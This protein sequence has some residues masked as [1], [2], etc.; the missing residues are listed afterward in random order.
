MD[1]EL[2][3]SR[4]TLELLLS[5][6]LTIDDPSL[7]QAAEPAREPLATVPPR[8]SIRAEVSSAIDT[9]L[10]VLHDGAEVDLVEDWHDY[11]ISLAEQFIASREVNPPTNDQT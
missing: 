4:L 8:D 3:V 6:H 11:A 9:L 7:K 10:K 2:P 1:P 5:S